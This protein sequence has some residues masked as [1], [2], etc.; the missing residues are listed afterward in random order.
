MEKE[1]IFAIKGN[2]V[3]PDRVVYNGLI[4]VQHEKIVSI[5]TEDQTTNFD[6]EL[7]ATGSFIFPGGIDA[8][9]H[10]YSEWSE[11]FENAGRAA[12]AGG[13]TTIIEM[14]YDADY[15]IKDV[16]TFERKKNKISE[17]L[18]DVAMLSTISKHNG[19]KDILELGEAGTC[20]FKVS[21]FNTDD[22]RFPRIDEGQLYEAFQTIKKT[23]RPVGVHA[24]TNDIVQHELAKYS[25][26]DTD[27]LSHIRSRPKIAE[28]TAA[29]TA[30]EIA[31]W[32]G[33]KLHL[34]HTTFKRVFDEVQRY[35]GQGVNV[36]AETCIHYL[37]FS[38]EDMY[39]EQGRLKINPPMRRK[40]DVMDLWDQLERGDIDLVTSDHA[41]WPIEKKNSPQI[42]SNAS[43][44]PGV[45]TLYP[46]LYSEG[47]AKGKLSIL[48]FAQLISEKPAERFGLSYR[49]GKI[50]E[51]MDADFV[52]ID[53]KETSRIDETSLHSQAGW[54]PYHE[55]SVQGVITHTISRGEIIYDR[56]TGV[57]ERHEGQ[58]IE[59]VF[60]A[61]DSQNKRKE[62]NSYV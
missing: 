4:K 2:I 20:G 3:L 37:T 30:M 41:P 25:K 53:P 56:E 62:E 5:H 57:N 60:T 8:H 44:A 38:E 47:V 12:A 15:M 28:A 49:K 17:S 35:R 18:V 54:S 31:Y 6:D 51:G 45:E 14:P 21:M 46:V 11:G 22:V 59:G 61:A 50:A 19:L 42:F 1:K 39:Q 33:V 55:W 24:E 43:G 48:R 9:V 29:L 36:T 58:F 10:C 23:G 52:I 13:I 40:E 34:Y 7:D 26:D 27:P 32:S 16:E